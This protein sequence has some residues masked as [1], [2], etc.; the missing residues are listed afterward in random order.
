M[1]WSPRNRSED[2][3]D[4]VDNNDDDDDCGDNRRRDIMSPTQELDM[5]SSKPS[6]PLLSPDSVHTLE[7][8][9][10][11]YKERIIRVDDD[12]I[13][14]DDDDDDDDASRDSFH[15]RRLV[16]DVTERERHLSSRDRSP[17]RASSS[18]EPRDDV[19]EGRSKHSEK[20]SGRRS[21][22]DIGDS[23]ES[24][25]SVSKNPPSAN[26]NDGRASSPTRNPVS[27]T[28]PVTRPKIWSISDFI[29]TTS[30]SSSSTSTNST[31]SST[32]NSHHTSTVAS[33][34]ALGRSSYITSSAIPSSSPQ[35]PHPNQG[36]LF[37][38]PGA[39]AHWPA[40]AAAA[41][42]AGLGGHFPLSLTHSTLSYPYNLATP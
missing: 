24:G 37:L 42:F 18:V 22:S 6:S 41:R 40:A 30:S 15:S 8:N 12:D 36:F 31:S 9:N 38:P 25:E 5:T 11:P 32:S 20:L 28:P 3:S 26:P 10:R 27:A 21:Q 7:N 2:G 17:L 33:P 35:R 19:G 13:S 16:A 29:N 1:T 14:E 39:A 23:R 4:D 34:S